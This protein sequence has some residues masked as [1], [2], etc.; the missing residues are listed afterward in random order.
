MSHPSAPERVATFAPTM[1][2]V[3]LVRNPVA[4]ALS[5][6]HHELHMRR[7]TRSFEDAVKEEAYQLSEDWRLRMDD[8]D[9]HKTNYLVKG[10]YSNHLRRWL[11]YFPEDHLLVLKSEDLFAHPTMTTRKVLAF[12]GESPSTAD[13]PSGRD[14]L[15]EN[16]LIFNM[17]RY[18]PLT[19]TVREDLSNYFAE[20]NRDLYSLLSWMN[21]PWRDA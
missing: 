4:R 19:S 1:K 11:D 15:S 5:H 2:L 7:E 13:V 20:A 9:P 18:D 14:P 17:Q 12:I 10:F 3:A 8:G 21:S 6:Y 16:P